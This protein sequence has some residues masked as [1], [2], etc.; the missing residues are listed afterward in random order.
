MTVGGMDDWCGAL[1]DWVE[2]M[3]RYAKMIDTQYLMHDSA[4]KL[5][6]ECTLLDALNIYLPFA[7]PFCLFQMARQGCQSGD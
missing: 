4:L 7:V 2:P 5:R 3:H 1:N 6:H